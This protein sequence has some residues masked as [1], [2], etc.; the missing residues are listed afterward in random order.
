VAASR[1]GGELARD[2]ECDVL[3]LDVLDAEPRSCLV[4]FDMPSHAAPIPRVMRCE[5][6]NPTTVIR[7]DGAAG[8]GGGQIV[9]TSV[10]LAAI[11]GRAV[12]I[13]AVRARRERPGLQ[14]Q[15]LAAVRAAAEICDAHLTGA[16]VGSV[17]VV[18]EPR[19]EPRAGDYTFDV[20]TAGAATLVLQSVLVPLLLAEGQSSIE[21]IGGTHQPMSPSADFLEHVYVPALRRFGVDV[22]VEYGPAGYYPRGGGRIRAI[23]AGTPMRAVD[24][25]TR[26]ERRSLDAYVVTSRLPDH[27]AQ[28]GAATVASFLP[29]AAI[30]TSTPSAFSAGAS[31]TIV[32][33]HEGGIAGFSS[34]GRPRLPMEQVATDAC[35]AFVRWDASGAACD[36][37]L[38]DQLVLPASLASGTSR[39]TTPRLTQHLRTVLEV[40]R[41]FLPLRCSL[42]GSCVVV[43]GAPV[44]AVR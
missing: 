16:H 25:S 32:A 44:R 2:P 40:T 20:R 30:H 34:I 23:V 22:E 43:D 17:H 12:E 37:R 15:H 21:I 33:T 11:T 31:V 41:T 42:E 4:Q 19:C 24:L 8:E 26:G 27:V 10:S 28:R 5:R 18:F 13:T 39:W 1:F 3:V 36:E 29:G 14:P 7:I 9:R 6:G 38:A 35:E